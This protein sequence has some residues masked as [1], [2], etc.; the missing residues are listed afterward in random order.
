MFFGRGGVE[1]QDAGGVEAQE[2]RQQ[3]AT[4]AGRAQP[5]ER[6]LAV[7]K[8][9]ADLYILDNVEEVDLENFLCLG[10][11]QMEWESEAMEGV[12]PPPQHVNLLHMAERRTHSVKVSLDR[13]VDED[14][15]CRTINIDSMH[16]IAPMLAFLPL[17][18]DFSASNPSSGSTK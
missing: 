15:I 8:E 14:C 1:A 13:L 17:M 12:P 7:L 4:P 16:G 6:V 18:K 9:T 11:V 5:T 2:M 10:K 3:D